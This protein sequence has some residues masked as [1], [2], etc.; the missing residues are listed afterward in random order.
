MSR[1]KNK[2]VDA[3]ATLASMTQINIGDMIQLV[4]IEVRNIQTHCCTFKESLDWKLQY[5]D[6][7][8]FIQH[9]EHPLG[10]SNN[11]VKTLR[12]MAMNYY[13]DSKILY[14]RLFD[15][16]LLRFLSRKEAEQVL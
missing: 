4:S 5:N 12:M 2:F 10:A 14:K 6:I 11:D 7:K 16:G 9:R 3:L 1:E 13:L 15:W 8:W